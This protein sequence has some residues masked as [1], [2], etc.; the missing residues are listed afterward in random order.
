[1]GFSWSSTLIDCKPSGYQVPAH[2]W[3]ASK[4][5]RYQLYGPFALALSPFSYLRIL[6]FIRK[7]IIN[8]VG[9]LFLNFPS[10]Y[11]LVFPSNFC[12]VFNPAELECRFIIRYACWAQTLS[13]CRSQIAI[14]RPPNLAHKLSS[15][16]PSPGSGV[17]PPGTK[18]PWVLSLSN[19]AVC[20]TF[21]FSLFFS[22]VPTIQD[23]G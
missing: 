8:A 5:Y 22:P 2:F 11:F 14:I 9:I 6:S 18:S 13:S 17:E 7:I 1:M 15:T 12:F 16:S 23:I 20:Q 10:Q 4:G 3:E 19:T 21:I